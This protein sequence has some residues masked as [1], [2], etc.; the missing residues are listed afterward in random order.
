MSF[1]NIINLYSIKAA[2]IFDVAINFDKNYK[3]YLSLSS[4]WKFNHTWECS[5]KQP[6]QMLHDSSWFNLIVQTKLPN[7]NTEY[8]EIFKFIE[9]AP[10]G[11]INLQNAYSNLYPK[12]DFNLL[13]ASFLIKRLGEAL[14]LEKKIPY[15]YENY[16]TN[17]LK[18]YTD[19]FDV[20][21]ITLKDINLVKK[22]T[23]HP[24]QTD[25]D[26][27]A[28]NLVG[29]PFNPF[30]AEAIVTYNS[31]IEEL[32]NK[33]TK[34]VDKYYHRDGDMNSEEKLELQS[35]YDKVNENL[36]LRNDLIKIKLAA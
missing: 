14:T 10:T 26:P 8:N 11:A 17:E 24:E 6:D 31:K 22:L 12:D 20:S 28:K 2:I 33:I 35:L 7:S 36:K 32:L 5:P 1:N 34:L 30:I 21:P 29:N 13:K 25:D 16:W 18:K 23:V 27:I 4:P 9:I 19:F 3:R 15:L